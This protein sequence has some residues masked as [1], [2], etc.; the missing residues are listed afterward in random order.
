M[1]REVHLAVMLSDIH[2]PIH[3]VKALSAIQD[4]L[5]DH[6]PE[7]IVQLGDLLDLGSLAHFIK[8]PAITG[9]L[10]E[11]FDLGFEFWQE[12][13]E[14]CPESI[15]V[16]I[17]GNHEKRLSRELC[18]HPQFHSLRSLTVPA[19]LRLDELDVNWVPYKK[20]WFMQKNLLITH[21]TTVRGK[22]GQS[23]MTEMENR[24]VSGISGH[25]HRLSLVTKTTMQGTSVWAEAG[26]LVDLEQVDY[27]DGQ[28][29]WQQGFVIVYFDDESFQI[30]TIPI[31]NGRFIFEGK[32]YK[33]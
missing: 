27:L 16:Q 20:N 15:C 26:H 2:K 4:L 6:Q 10:Q 30:Q 32:V 5:E 14:R 23:G 33:G 7:L 11:E 12:V 28:A 3:D 17:E 1:Q 13:R 31:N 18:S 8:H 22:S 21:G 19:Q 25:V 24:W 29:N 9:T